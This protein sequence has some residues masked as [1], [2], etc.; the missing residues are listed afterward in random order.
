MVSSLVHPLIS[1][2]GKAI[3]IAIVLLAL[4]A[5]FTFS[6]SAEDQVLKIFHAGSLAAPMED[7]EEIFEASHPGVDVQRE[8]SGSNAAVRKITELERCADILNSADYSLIPG[9]MYPDYADWYIAYAGNE[10]VLAYT[11]D[12]KYADEVNSENWYDI[13]RKPDV[14]YFFSNPNEDPCGYRSPMVML[15]AEGYYGDDDIFED[16]IEANVAIKASEGEVGDGK[17][18]SGDDEG[19]GEDGEESSVWTITVPATEDMDVNLD[20]LSIRPKSVEALALLDSGD[21]DYAFEYKSVAEQHGLRYVDLPEEIDLGSADEADGYAKVR[22]ELADGQLKTAKPIVYG[23]TIPTCSEN[24]DL[25]EEFASLMLSEEGVEVFKENFQPPIVPAKTD[26]F[27][28]VP[29]SL[30]PYLE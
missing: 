8:A 20:K 12:S 3:K 24:T 16:L 22:I 21:I 27:E 29:D 14:K 15:L 25:A 11:E 17:G 2:K 18:G 19:E 28:A 23:F 13:L 10:M 26:N 30:K 7:L 9:M 4:V 5:I 1:M 6:A